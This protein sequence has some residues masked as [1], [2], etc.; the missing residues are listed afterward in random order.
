[1]TH[2]AKGLRAARSGDLVLAKQEADALARI[3]VDLTAKKDA[4][5]R[6]VIDLMDRIRVADTLAGRTT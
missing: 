4:Y 3:A 5:Y 1:M 2:F 6:A